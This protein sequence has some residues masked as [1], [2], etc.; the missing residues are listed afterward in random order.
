MRPPLDIHS[1]LNAE[2]DD[3]QN[4]ALLRNA[5][6]PGRIRPG[7]IVIA[8]TARYCSAVRVTAVDSDGQIRFSGT[9]RLVLLASFALVMLLI[10]FSQHLIWEPV[11]A[12]RAVN[13]QGRYLIPIAPILFLFVSSFF[14][15]TTKAT[16]AIVMMFALFSCCLTAE[17]LYQRYYV[18]AASGLPAA[19]KQLEPDRKVI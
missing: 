4:W 12:N 8:G 11:G 9:H 10:L 3:G 5:V 15:Q 2:D 6:D 17:T 13:V 7:A 14:S 19:R 16:A 1:D 18:D